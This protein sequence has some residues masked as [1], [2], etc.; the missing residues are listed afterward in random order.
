MQSLNQLNKA[1][2]Q[3]NAIMDNCHVR[4]VFTPNDFKTAQLISN[5]LSEKTEL[6]D[7]QSFSGERASFFLKN[8]SRSTQQIARKLMTPG[9]VLLLHRGEEIIFVAGFSPIKAN[10]LFYFQDENFKSRLLPAPEKSDVCRVKPRPQDKP[11]LDEA[12]RLEEPELSQE[13]L[14]VELAQQA[15][16]ILATLETWDSVEKKRDP[17]LTKEPGLKTQ[18]LQKENLP[19]PHMPGKAAT[20]E[21]DEEEDIL[22]MERGFSI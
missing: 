10:K 12:P 21:Y 1:Y 5:M 16:G 19:E 9:E 14:A 15:A 18:V 6:I 2:T 13:L 3:D 11:K 17:Y 22:S 20:Q 8:V 7:N 4:T